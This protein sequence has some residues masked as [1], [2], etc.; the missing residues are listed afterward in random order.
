MLLLPSDER[1]WQQWFS[2]DFGFGEIQPGYLVDLGNL[3]TAYRSRL[4]SA[5]HL[6]EERFSMDSLTFQDRTASYQDIRCSWV[7]FCDGIE[8]TTNPWF[9]FLPF[10]PNKGEALILETDAIPTSYVFKKGMHLVPWKDNLFWVGASYAWQFDDDRPSRVFRER[11]EA[12]LSQWLQIPFRVVDHVSSV[13]PATLERRPLVGFHPKIKP[14]GLLNGMG[15]KG[16]S[17]A[18]YFAAQLVSHMTQQ[19]PLAPEADIT[20]FRNLLSKLR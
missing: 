6:R 9:G 5:G 16:C 1:R 18:P 15:T 19:T 11:T 12:L 2:Y 17:L 14:L 4:R 10:A 7:I 3:L 20:R 8:S 13:R